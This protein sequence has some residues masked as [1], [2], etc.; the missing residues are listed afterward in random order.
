[1]YII[2]K[3]IHYLKIPQ[4]Y[5]IKITFTLPHYSGD[6]EIHRSQSRIII[7]LNHEAFN[8][9]SSL[10]RKI[11]LTNCHL[12]TEWIIFGLIIELWKIED[13][14]YLIHH[15][16]YEIK[17]FTTS[18]GEKQKILPTKRGYPEGR[19]IWSCFLFSLNENMVF[20]YP[21]TFIFQ[22]K[23]GMFKNLLYL[24]RQFCSSSE[25]VLLSRI[26]IFDLA[27]LFPLQFSHL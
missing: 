21:L 13:F 27:T 20:H 18:S 10:F 24:D 4:R 5:F 23:Q 7:I 2:N 25:P 1:M 16:V 6:I 19:N 8:N 17:G 22:N 15:N 3:Y 11:I 14:L 26:P 9:Y 12:T